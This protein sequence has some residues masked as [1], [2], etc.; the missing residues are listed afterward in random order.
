MVRVF[1]NGCGVLRTFTQAHVRERD[2]YMKP[3]YLFCKRTFHSS[4]VSRS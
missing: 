3:M 2:T 1:L 4:I